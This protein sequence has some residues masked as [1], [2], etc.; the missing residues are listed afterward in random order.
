MPMLPHPRTFND[1]LG[2]YLDAMVEI[3]TAMDRAYHRAAARYGFHCTGCDDNCCYTHFYHYTHLEYGFL[4]RGYRLLDGAG[5]AQVHRRAREVIAS[6]DAAGKGEMA[7]RPLC[8]LNFDGRCVLYS[9]RPMIC[10]LHGIPHEFQTMNGRVIHAPGC[11]AFT[12]RHGKLGYHK[13]DRTPFYRQMA[14]LESDFKK[15]VGVGDKLKMTI[16]E[17]IVSF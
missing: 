2:P 10:R 12:E 9:H 14:R 5:C 1:K 3:Y 6:G 13:F 15:A 17:M 11:D 16:A 8:P 4:R 7:G